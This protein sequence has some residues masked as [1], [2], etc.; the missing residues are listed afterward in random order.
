MSE[1][2]VYPGKWHVMGEEEEAEEDEEEENHDHDDEEE[3]EEEPVNFSG[4]HHGE[5]AYFQ[6]THTHMAM[7]HSNDGDSP[8]RWETATR[9]PS[10]GILEIGAALSEEGR[11]ESPK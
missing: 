11:G 6:A 7:S 10:A 3:K 9:H 1:P 4:C 5:S 2:A 8:S